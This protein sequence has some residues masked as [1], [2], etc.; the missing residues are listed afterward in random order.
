MF[1]LINLLVHDKYLGR[2]SERHTDSVIKK[3]KLLAV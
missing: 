3:E 2:Y 1:V